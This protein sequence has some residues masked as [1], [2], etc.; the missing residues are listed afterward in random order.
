VT[1]KSIPSPAPHSAD[2]QQTEGEWL[3]VVDGLLIHHGVSDAG[4]DWDRV[5][6]DT[7]EERARQILGDALSLPGGGSN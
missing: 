7:R 3:V 2:T 4:I 6:D 5:I 1:D